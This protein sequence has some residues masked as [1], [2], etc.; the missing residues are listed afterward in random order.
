MKLAEALILR[1]DA[2]K[3]IQQL[4]ERLA[5][6]ARVQEGEEPA[7]NP[8]ELLDEL[9]RALETF[10]EMVQRINRTNSATAFDEGRTL[11]DALADRDTLSL[12]HS[13]LEG[14]IKGVAQPNFRYGRSEIKFVLTVNVAELQKRIDA[15]ARQYRELD[16]RIQAMN[17]NIDLLEQ[18]ESKSSPGAAFSRVPG[19]GEELAER[20]ADELDIE[21]LEELEEAAHD[22]RLEAVEGF[23]EKRVNSV[24]TA[25]AGML[26][27]SARR[28]QRDRTGQ[29]GQSPDRPSVELLLKV[30]E[31]YRQG[32]EKDRL[33][34][35][36]PRRFNPDDE[37]WLPV[38]HTKHDGW[39]FTALYSN[40]AQAH[41]LEKTDDWVVIYYEKNGQQRQNTVVT[42]TQGALKGKR[43]V[44]GRS[45]ENQQHYEASTASK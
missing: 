8:Q 4:R 3:R 19:I 1:A 34:K 13:V 24:K 2:Q 25:L 31:E 35:I 12:E 43:V 39:K 22:G 16:S 6:S 38:L 33:Q 23:G 14:L 36:S 40:T 44:R 30:D 18:L 32:A 15:L 45:L 28:Q 20:I 37:A 9:G 29:N 42:E 11:T 41:K 21:T 5:R 26:S 10:R 17:W 7:E 27:R